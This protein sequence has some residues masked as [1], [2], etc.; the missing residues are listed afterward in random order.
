[1]MFRATTIDLATVS[2]TPRI[3]ATGS[4]GC[5]FVGALALTRA[6]PLLHR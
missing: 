3:S 2:M 4:P 6:H 5:G 1:M